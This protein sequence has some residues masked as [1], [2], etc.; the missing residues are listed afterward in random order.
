[1]LGWYRF[2]PY[3]I[4]LTVLTAEAS[5]AVPQAE[6]RQPQKVLQDSINGSTFEMVNGASSERYVYDAVNLEKCAL[7]W[8]E[9][10]ET[11]ESGKRTFRE[12]TETTA[13][14][15]VIDEKQMTPNKLK[16]GG[17][18]VSLQTKGLENQ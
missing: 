9:E 11:W 17:Y 12:V 13:P 4:A 5:I 7:K 14:L 16:N 18:V 8:T 6:S 2:F 10:H 1:M 15:D 3:L